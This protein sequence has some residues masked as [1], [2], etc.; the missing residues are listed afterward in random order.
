MKIKNDGLRKKG[1]TM[2]IHIGIEILPMLR[3]ILHFL[4]ECF[5]LSLGMLAPHQKLRARFTSW[6]RSMY[7]LRRPAH[8]FGLGAGVSD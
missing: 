5:P 7:E 2:A 8:S 3:H 6:S 4:S 1:L